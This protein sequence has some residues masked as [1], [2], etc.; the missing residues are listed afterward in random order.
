MGY[1]ITRSISII[2]GWV[3]LY[4]CLT[5]TWSA[6]SVAPNEW[7]ET[8]SANRN[9][10]LGFITAVLRGPQ[11]RWYGNV[12]RTTSCIKF[13]TDFPIPGARRRERH[14]RWSECVKIDVSNCGLAGVDPQNWLAWRVGVDRAAVPRSSSTYHRWVPPVLLSSVP[15]AGGRVT[16]D[17]E[18]P[19][20][21]RSTQY[22]SCGK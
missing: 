12:Q 5:A 7:D 17:W 6:K 20:R 18:L 10:T 13:V 4:C 8:P 2:T 3:L 21:I 11:L 22:A 16:Q 15:V 19:L 9:L 1:K 14:K